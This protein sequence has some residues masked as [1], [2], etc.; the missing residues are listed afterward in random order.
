MDG[1]E[2]GGKAG[3]G[4]TPGDAEPGHADVGRLEGILGVRF[5]DQRLLAEAVT[6]SSFVGGGPLAGNERLE[7]LG[8]AVLKLV[9]AWHLYTT[10]PEAPEGELSAM[11]G[12]SV[13]EAALAEA[14]RRLGIGPFLRLGHSLEV[15]GGRS[16]PSVL[17]DALEAVLGAVF[18]DQG[19]DAARQLAV[20]ELAPGS[21]MGAARDGQ[22]VRNYKAILQEFFQKREKSIPEYQVVG[23]EGPD[24]DKTFTVVVKS[25]DGPIGLGRGKTK[26]TAEQAAAAHALARIGVLPAAG[27]ACVQGGEVCGEDPGRDEGKP[28]PAPPAGLA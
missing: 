14:A 28:D 4:G 3:N 11:L 15:T 19:L 24:H 6:H 12:R 5:K 18:L 26:K 25:E 1:L 9:T 21:G 10:H 8:D 22:A 7:F 23:E 13:S 27:S 2:S 17:A 20:R 16:L